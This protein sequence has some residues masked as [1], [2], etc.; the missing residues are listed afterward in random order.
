MGSEGKLYIVATPI[1]NMEDITLRALRILGEVDLIAA[2]DTR[3]TGRLLARHGIK[4]PMVSLNQHNELSRADMLIARMRA[5][6]DIAYCSDAGTPALSDPGAKL[7][8]SCREA[9]LECVPIPGP[10][11]LATALSVAGLEDGF[12]F[13]GFLPSSG[14]ARNRMLRR[15]QEVDWHIVLYE[16]PHRL[17]KTLEAL[18]QALG[19]RRLTIARE[20]TKLHE[21][22]LECSI[23]DALRQFEHPK[24]EFVLI[25]HPDDAE[26]PS[27]MDAAGELMQK[28]LADGLPRRQAAKQVA[29]QCGIQRNAAYALGLNDSAA[30]AHEHDDAGNAYDEGEDTEDV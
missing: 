13:C 24:G 2:E 8:R 3:V 15:L 1:G 12:L 10:S 26:Q 22:V 19:D 17:G 20:L 4:K 29:E 25:V 14:S 27:D 28:L 7:V 30:A 18:Q 6:E 11:A 9:R 5:G 16:A 23:S 21:E